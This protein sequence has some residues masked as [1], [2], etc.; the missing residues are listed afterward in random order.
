M[1]LSM[2]IINDYLE[3]IGNLENTNLDEYELTDIPIWS[4]LMSRHTS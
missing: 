2:S 1:N 4:N 3:L